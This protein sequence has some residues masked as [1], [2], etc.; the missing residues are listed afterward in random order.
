[1][2]GSLEN[3]PVRIK[4][5]D[6]SGVIRWFETATAK[7]HW[8]VVG[9]KRNV[10]SQTANSRWLHWSRQAAGV[11]HNAEVLT[12]SKAVELLI[13][14]GLEP[15]DCRAMRSREFGANTAEIPFAAF[16]KDCNREVRFDP[17]GYEI[18]SAPPPEGGASSFT[19]E[20]DDY[21]DRE[22][23][24]RHS[25]GRWVMLELPGFDH[26]YDLPLIYR[27][28]DE[29]AARWLFWKRF[30]VPPELQCFTK[31]MVFDLDAADPM[32]P[33]Q[34]SRAIPNWNDDDGTLEFQGRVVRKVRS[35]AANV[36]T[37]FSAFQEDRWPDRM[38]SPFSD[39]HK[40]REAIASANAGLEVIRLEADGT[41]EGVKWLAC[42]NE[43]D[44]SG[45]EPNEIPF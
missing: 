9:E 27:Y 19:A 34:A 44:I 2:S 12:E 14:H 30:D 15:P 31:E 42:S 4:F 6:H 16:D 10:L 26:G 36:R 1:M 5:R 37:L 24:Y 33:E 29:S 32:S 25:D 18:Y 8:D 22:T 39:P 23:L 45:E 7:G 21:S 43:T 40:L 13:E 28:D 20:S 41:G 3:L 11:L 38:D 35:K 17:D